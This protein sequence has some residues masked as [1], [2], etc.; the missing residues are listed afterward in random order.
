LG[1]MVVSFATAKLISAL[2]Y[3][4]AP[5]DPTTYVAVSSLLLAVGAAAC[6]VPAWRATRIDP[7]DALRQEQ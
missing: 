1:G 6:Y 7:L 3:G 2:L 4:I 5:T